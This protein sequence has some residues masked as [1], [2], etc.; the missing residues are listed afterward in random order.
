MRLQK[1]TSRKV[2]SKEYA[3][4]VVVIPP[5]SVAKLGWQEGEELEDKVQ[6]DKLVIIPKQ[7]D[8]RVKPNQQRN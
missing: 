2:E 7:K 1:H 8:T 5:E 4:Y 6:G 3:K